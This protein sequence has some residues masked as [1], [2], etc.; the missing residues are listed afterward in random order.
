[1]PIQFQSWINKKTVLWPRPDK[2]KCWL[3]EEGEEMG[4]AYI[5]SWKKVEGKM[6]LWKYKQTC[7]MTQMRGCLSHFGSQAWNSLLGAHSQVLPI[8]TI[9]M[10]CVFRHLQECL[11][12]IAELDLIVANFVGGFKFLQ[13]KGNVVV[14]RWRAAA[15]WRFLF[16]IIRDNAATQCFGSHCAQRDSNDQTWAIKCGIRDLLRLRHA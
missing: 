4:S 8:F 11:T 14:A 15:N 10:L 5:I 9:W 1:M 3:F 12:Y 16:D 13:Q 2:W 6:Q 7:C